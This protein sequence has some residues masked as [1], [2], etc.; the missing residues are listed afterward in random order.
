M[1]LGLSASS[2]FLC[3]ALVLLDPGVK[4]CGPGRP[5]G[6]PLT[7]GRVPEEVVL[8]VLHAWLWQGAIIL[9][10]RSEGSPGPTSLPRGPW[11]SLQA[12]E[13]GGMGRRDAWVPT[14]QWLSHR[15]AIWLALAGGGRGLRGA[16]PVASWGQGRWGRL[17][18]G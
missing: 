13:C 6:L 18:V 12:A 16:G 8:R 9:A 11:P 17:C 2:H 4:S 7:L 3:L 5:Q 1:S 10:P 14:G 15:E